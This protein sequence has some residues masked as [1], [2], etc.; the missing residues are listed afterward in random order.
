MF[1]HHAIE[2]VPFDLRIRPAHVATGQFVRN[3]R[4]FRTPSISL[5]SRTI[6]LAPSATKYSSS[7]RY[8][9]T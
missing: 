2:T 9:N 8:P 3:T 5:S 1:S 4:A 7:N 6:N